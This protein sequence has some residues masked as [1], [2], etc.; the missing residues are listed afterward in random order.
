MERSTSPRYV[1][2]NPTELDR[3]VV[4]LDASSLLA[5]RNTITIGLS[6]EVET[7][8]IG[9]DVEK[10]KI[11]QLDVNTRQ[12]HL[13]EQMLVLQGYQFPQEGVKRCS[14]LSVFDKSAGESA[15]DV[16]NVDVMAPQHG[17]KSAATDLEI[18]GTSASK[19]RPEHMQNIRREA[20]T[21]WLWCSTEETALSL[22]Q[23]EVQSLVHHPIPSLY[24]VVTSCDMLSHCRIQGE[25][26]CLGSSEAWWRNLG[27]K[28]AMKHG[29]K[30][31]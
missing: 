15:A 20:R 4:F 13:Q 28:S 25:S 2:Q 30:Q 3:T 19:S 31:A 22:V 12:L 24:L 7:R 18:A 27:A 14:Q 23:S 6:G 21:T 17:A 16:P 9:M 11:S 5:K 1:R 29:P 10:W 8:T 26:R